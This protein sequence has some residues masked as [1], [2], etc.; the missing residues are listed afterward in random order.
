MFLLDTDIIIYS[1]KGVKPVVEQFRLHAD[2]PK[3]ISVITYGELVYGANKSA[4]VTKNL[5]KV[6]GLRGILPIIEVSS[7]IMD[8][9]GLLK[10]QMS[11][12]GI[13]VD[14][15][16]LLIGA[17]AIAGG[18]TLVTNNEKHFSKI[19]GLDFVNWNR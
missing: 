18:Y 15:F 2:A 5:V 19:P 8:C 6:Y 11:K 12:Q 3:A 4:Q 13:T 10:A 9:F 17:T 16:D 7:A 1:F 14:D